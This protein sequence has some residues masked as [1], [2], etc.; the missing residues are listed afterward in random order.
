MNSRICMLVLAVSLSACAGRA[1]EQGGVPEPEAQPVDPLEGFNRKVFV[2]NEFVDKYAAKPAAKGY[3]KV[4][5]G[6]LDDAVSRF[7]EN[8]SD[9]GSSV[10][11]VLQW[12]W[13]EAGNNFGRFTV[14]STLG[15]G[16]LFDVASDAGLDKTPEDFGLT[17]GKW[18]FD[19]GPYLVL[20]F[21]GPSNVRAA[22]GRVPDYWLWAPNYI[23]HQLTEYSVDAVYIIDKRAGL[24]DLERA[25]VGDKYTFLRD[26]YMQRRRY[27]A[28]EASARDDFG[29]GFESSEDDW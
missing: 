12:E 2:F 28:G 21:L 8:L 18:G 13:A 1:P 9:L 11:G 16:G 24:L 20:P 27:Q 6:W 29:E 25:I 26:A 3:R 5:P 23:D 22:V 15:V 10:N 19:M 4:T 14:N 17:L 7:F